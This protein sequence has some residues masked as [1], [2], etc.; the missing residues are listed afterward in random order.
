M[1]H[2][3]T[4]RNLFS[5]YHRQ[6]L[7]TVTIPQAGLVKFAVV[8]T[9]TP[10]WTTQTIGIDW[11]NSNFNIGGRTPT[12]STWTVTVR[13]DVDGSVIKALK[14]WRDLVFNPETGGGTIPSQYKRD[15]LIELLNHQGGTTLSYKLV[16]AFP[17]SLGSASLGYT[18][19]AIVTY[20]VTFSYDYPLMF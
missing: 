4:I 3:N 14:A 10:N 20:T 17:T 11:M 19:N 15:I 18:N 2:I 5:D 8:S 7:F 9:S 13:S 12:A 1:L 16:G 6:Y